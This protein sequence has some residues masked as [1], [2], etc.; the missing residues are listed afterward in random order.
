MSGE[1]LQKTSV[2]PA[3]SASRQWPAEALPE[4]T[5][6]GL[7]SPAD[8]ILL[9]LACCGDLREEVSH[10]GSGRS[11]LMLAIAKCHDGLKE[12]HVH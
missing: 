8:G 9:F 7:D 2:S 4:P 3:G 6:L 10:E 12:N 1:D 11:T 5:I